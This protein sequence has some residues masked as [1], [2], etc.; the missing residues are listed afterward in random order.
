MVFVLWAAPAWTALLRPLSRL[1]LAD[2]GVVSPGSMEATVLQPQRELI[3]FHPSSNASWLLRK[4]QILYQ[5]L[6]DDSSR[7]TFCH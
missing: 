4:A 6:S 5:R 1:V 3:W 7:E 2:M